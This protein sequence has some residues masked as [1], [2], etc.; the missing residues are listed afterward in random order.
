MSGQTTFSSFF[1][2]E[3]DVKANQVCPTERLRH[4]SDS[5]C[6]DL[7]EISVGSSPLLWVL[8]V[9]LQISERLMHVTAYSVGTWLATN[10]W[11]QTEDI[12]F[13]GTYITTDKVCSS[14]FFWTIAVPGK[15]GPRPIVWLS[16]DLSASL[17]WRLVLHHMHREQWAHTCRKRGRIELSEKVRQWW[18]G[19]GS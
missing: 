9:V 6:P 15:T 18:S 1:I 7:L 19:T 12:A 16:E 14:I 10:R 3:S 4:Q 11:A 2:K 5:C 8:P 17:V 13:V